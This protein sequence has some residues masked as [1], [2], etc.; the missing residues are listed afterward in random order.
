MACVKSDQGLNILGISSKN[1]QDARQIASPNVSMLLS[2]P[3][4]NPPP[5]R[6]LG[7]GSN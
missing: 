6:H 3:L 2:L 4:L 1:V 5:N 7:T